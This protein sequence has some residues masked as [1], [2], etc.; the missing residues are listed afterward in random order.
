M[1]GILDLCK[2]LI[3]IALVVA[4]TSFA[5]GMVIGVVRSIPHVAACF[6]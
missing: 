5:A 2:I 4:A 3:A 1:T 6:K